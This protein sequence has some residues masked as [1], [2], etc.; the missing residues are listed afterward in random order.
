[1]IP[2]KI[3]YV[4]YT[5]PAG[6]PSL[7]HNSRILAQHGWHV[8]FLGTDVR[9]VKALRFLPHPNIRLKLIPFCRRGLPQKFHYFFYCCWVVVHTIFWRPQWVYASDPFSCPAALF[10]DLLGFKVIY[11]EHDSPN[12][13]SEQKLGDAKRKIRK[14]IFT[15]LISR[16]R[17]RLS[18]KAEMCILP[19]KERMNRFIK[20]TGREGKTFCV[21]NCPSLE[22]L[23]DSNETEARDD[24]CWIL[25]HGSLVPERLPVTI[26]EAM[27]VLPDQVKFRVVGYETIGSRGYESSLRAKAGQLGL[28]ERVEFVGAVS[29]GGL[30]QY[31]RN[32]HIGLA[33]MPM[34]SSDV[35]MQTM[36]GASNKP[37]DYLAC[38]LALLVSDLPDWRKMY[39]EPG[40]GL[41]CD[42][43]D[44]ASIAKAIQWFLDHPE[45]RQ[46]MGAQGQ[47]QVLQEWHYE[48][49]F[50]PVLELLNQKQPEN[51]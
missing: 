36:T 43:G 49:C 37:F 11:H 23:P 27:A 14:P 39:V 7:E 42:P 32:C 4:Q 46:Q 28:A 45:A 30:F 10:L 12:V 41:A 6:Y 33:L 5:N 34:A 40:Y 17:E 20:E 9:E 48:K 16:V 35:N 51:Q 44:S 26:F 19:N 22:E 47:K 25:Y 50:M 1:M 13:G 31:A 2:R 29:R 24:S 38:G 21:W 15:A 18:K 8:L 3:L